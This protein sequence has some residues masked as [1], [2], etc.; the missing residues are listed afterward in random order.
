MVLY[1]QRSVLP[2][3]DQQDVYTLQFDPIA[4][5]VFGFASVTLE[6]RPH[7]YYCMRSRNNT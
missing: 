2:F 1:S 5:A 3:S 7:Y 4:K 6:V